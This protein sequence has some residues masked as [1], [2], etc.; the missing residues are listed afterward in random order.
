MT[1]YPKIENEVINSCLIHPEIIAAYLFGSVARGCLKP[2]SDIDVAVLLEETGSNDFPLAGFMAKLE[3]ILIR[4]VDVVVL[5]RADELLKYEIRRHGRLIFERDPILR[6]RFEIQGRKQ[7][8]D[9]MYLHRRYTQ[10]V[11]YG[12]PHG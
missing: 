11:L 5:N 10:K 3:K 12:K 7:F 1:E 4:P 9:F 6:K 2:A 8:E